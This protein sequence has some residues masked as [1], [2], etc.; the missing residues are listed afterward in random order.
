MKGGADAGRAGF[1]DRG[2][3]GT[4]LE[5]AYRFERWLSLRKSLESLR[6]R[7]DD[8]DS[9]RTIQGQLSLVGAEISCYLAAGLT[10]AALTAGERVK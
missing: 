2:R 10:L 7:R 8:S 6:R 9:V 5:S 1:W 3:R 4:A